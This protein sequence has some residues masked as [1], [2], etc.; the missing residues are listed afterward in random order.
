[1]KKYNVLQIF[2]LTVFLSGCGPKLYLDVSSKPECK[3]HLGKV[4]SSEVELQVRGITFNINGNRDVNYVYLE[5][6]PATGGNQVVF[7]GALEANR[8]FKIVGVVES[9][10]YGALH[11]YYVVKIIG[12]KKY[13][14]YPVIISIDTNVNS[15]NLG[16]DKN[17]FTEIANSS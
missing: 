14:K 13:D 5:V 11:R 9:A 8:I 16:L 12:N 6:P 7:K 15:N 17:Y 2:I 4:F 10:Y 1:M 3:Q